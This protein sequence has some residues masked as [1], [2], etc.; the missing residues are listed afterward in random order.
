MRLAAA[1]AF[2]RLGLVALLQQ[3]GNFERAGRYLGTLGQSSDPADPD[4]PYHPHGIAYVDDPADPAGDGS[5][6]GFYY[7]NTFDLKSRPLFEIEAW[8]RVP[9]AKLIWI[10]A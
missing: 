6:A 10:W 8:A 3:Q 1:A 5:R 2:R 9:E 4:C 7:V